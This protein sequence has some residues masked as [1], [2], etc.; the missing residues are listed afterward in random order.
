MGIFHKS[1]GVICGLGAACY[2]Y[3][4]FN[5]VGNSA[6]LIQTAYGNG[7][8][9]RRGVVYFA[10]GIIVAVQGLAV[11]VIRPA[12]IYLGFVYGKRGLKRKLIVIV[13]RVY[14]RRNGIASRVQGAV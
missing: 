4:Q 5:F 9:M 12:E 7:F 6:N 8:A 13:P 1:V 11:G 14:G 2:R 10:E 3:R